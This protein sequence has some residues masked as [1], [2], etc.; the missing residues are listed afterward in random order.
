MNHVI[1]DQTAHLRN[2]LYSPEYEHDACGV[3]F[4]AQVEG[5]RSNQVLRFALQSLCNLAHRGAVDAD[6]KTGDGAGV[7]TQIPYR[8]L[9]PEVKKLGHHLYKEAD[10]GVGMI[11]L[12]HDNAYAQARAKA[13]IE[14]VIESRELFLFGW[15]QVPIN[16]KVLGDKAASTLPRIEQVLVG[17]PHGMTDDE[18]ERRLF[19]SRNE[20]EKRAA[21]DQIRHFYIPSFSHRLIAYK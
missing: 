19:L 14:E 11:F 2:S 17:R 7:M 6:A 12:P 5:K 3:G 20:I 13:I 8:I 21:E 16:I 9:V 4:I 18:Y 10:L 1:Q 15:R